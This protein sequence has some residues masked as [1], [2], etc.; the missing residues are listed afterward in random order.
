MI[1]K[2]ILHYKI[3]EKLGE[4][5]MGIVYKAEDSRLNRQVA[6]KVLPPHLLIAQDDRA[7]FQREAKAAAAL[8]HAAI[9]TVYEI[10]EFEGAPFIA[11]EYV[12]GKTLNHHI[13]KG[14]LP[15]KDAINVAIRVAEGLKAAHAK[16]IVHRDI[17]SSNIIL[18]PEMQAKILDFGLAKTSMS[19][20]LT[21]MG[22]T[23]GTMAY[24]SPEQVNGQDVDQR[25]DLWSLGVVLYEMISGRLPFRAEYD[26][27]IL[28]AILN[29][30]PQ[31]LTA[32]RTGVPMSLEWIV[33]K[34]MAK[35][36][37]ER[38]QNA[39]D[40]IIDLKAVDLKSSG[41]S[42]VS[43]ASAVAQPTTAQTVQISDTEQRQ[44]RFPQ[45][46]DKF[47]WIA[48]GVLALAVIV[49]SI[50]YFMKPALENRT[51]RAVIEAPENIKIAF[52]TG[53]LEGGHLALSPNGKLLAFVGQDSAGRS[54][55]WVRRLD[56]LT[57]QN[58]NG[59][60]GAYYPFWSADSRYIGFFA[61]G[62]LKKINAAGGPVLSIC[63]AARGRGGTWN[64]DDVVVFTPEQEGGIF[65]VSANGGSPQQITRMDSTSSEQ[66]HRWAS[67]LPDGQHFLYFVRYSGSEQSEND[68]VY[69]GSLDGKTRKKIMNVHS[70]A[71]F[72]N[73]YL[74]YT[75][76]NTLIAQKFDT[77]SLELTGDAI[78][79]AENI[80]YSNIFSRGAFTPS[81]NGLLIY[82]GGST[83]TGQKLVWYDWKGNAGGSISLCLHIQ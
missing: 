45:S 13:E 60:E 39:N 37:A 61:D 35:D 75:R 26:Q 10:N 34:L 82:L 6:I 1:G 44:K 12:E 62:K 43:T 28:F 78:P 16:G 74:I 72:A 18:D 66:T 54:S 23:I 67:F 36:P 64:S 73:G 7:R 68:A 50:L 31:P 47:A 56:A 25:S 30:Q 42:R 20:R 65:R 19:T 27:A 70:N 2:E 5:G 52:E 40:L 51:I 9:A 76:D 41:F 8:N 79:L 53:G 81:T 24:M 38:Y 59:T 83:R 3:L 22:S 49:L 17:K 32:I 77:G 15:L 58:L 80:Q 69:V 33:N 57:A 21:Q 55:L 48:V 63:D 71:Y 14:P 29:E 4:G 11:M 46:T